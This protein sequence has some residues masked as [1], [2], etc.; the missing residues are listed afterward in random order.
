MPFDITYFL[1]VG[2]TERKKSMKKRIFTLLMVLVMSVLMGVAASAVDS[3]KLEIA[4]VGSGV[5]LTALEEGET[6]D[7]YL[8]VSPMKKVGTSNNYIYRVPEDSATAAN[9]ASAKL[10]EM[11]Y[12]LTWDKASLEVSA[13]AVKA[14]NAEESAGNGYYFAHFVKIGITTKQDPSI[15]GVGSGANNTGTLTLDYSTTKANGFGMYNATT[16]PSVGAVAKITFRVVSGAEGGTNLPITLKNTYKYNGSGASITG[17]NI[18]VS[19]VAGCEHANKSALSPAELAAAGLTNVTA[20]CLVEGKTWYYCSDCEKNI[21]ITSNKLDHNY[22]TEKYLKEPTCFEGGQK[23]LYCD[24]EG[25]TEYDKTNVTNVG[26]YGHD[27]TAQNHAYLEPDCTTDGY[28]LYWCSRCNGVAP[29]SNGD[30]FVYVVFDSGVFKNPNGS[31]YT[32]IPNEVK[33]AATGHDW[34]WNRT[35]GNIAYYECSRECGVAEKQVDLAD[36]VRYVSDAGGGDGSSAQSTVR[37]HEAFDAFKDFPADVDCTIYLVGDVS[38]YHHQTSS[39]NS[40][41]KNFEEARHDATVTITTAPNTAKAELHFPFATASQYFLGGPTV[42]DNITVTSTAVGTTS[43]SSQSTTIYARGFDITFT[44]NFETYGKNGG[45]FDYSKLD[46]SLSLAV[47]T[48]IKVPDC[49]L[50]VCGGFTAGGGY[51][52]ADI[53][54]YKS[55]M[56]IYGG[57]FFVIAGGSRNSV[58]LEDTVVDIHVGGNAKVAQ[59]IPFNVPA[60]TNVDGSAV[61]IHYHGGFE[62]A[63]AYVAQ[64]AATGGDYTVN[65]LFHEGS[66]DIK[67]GDFMMG[68]GSHHKNVN[69]FYYTY[70][71]ETVKMAN[72]V[73][74]KVSKYTAQYMISYDYAPFA[75]WCVEWLGGHDF[76][77]GQCTFCKIEPCQTHN[78]VNKVISLPNCITDGVSY[79]YCTVCF[80]HIGEEIR[81]PLIPDAH[82]YG[83]DLSK[84]PIESVCEYCGDVRYTYS[85]ENTG[86]IYV[87]DNGYGDGGFTPDYPLNDYETA[88]KMAAAFNGDATIYVVDSISVYHNY[89]GTSANTVFI[90]PKHEN[91][92]TVKGYKNVGIFKFGADKGR[93]LYNLNGDTT[94]ENI[95]FSEGSANNTSNSFNYIIAAHNHLTIG[96][97][98]TTAFERNSD[99]AYHNG[100]I[101]VVGGCY[102]SNYTISDTNN[103]EGTDTHITLHSGNFYSVYGG[104]V[105]SDCA[106]VNGTINVEF[107][108]DI[109]ISDV[110]AA[111]SASRAAGDVIITVKDANVSTANTFSIVGLNANDNANT[112]ENELYRATVKNVTLK[113]YSGS[114]IAQSFQATQGTTALR[115]LGATS[116]ETPDNGFEITQHLEKLTIC[117][118]PSN[119]SAVTAVNSLKSSPMYVNGYTELMLE[120]MCEASLDGQHTPNGAAKEETDSTCSAQ[121]YAIYTC[122]ACGEDYTEAKNIVPHDYGQATLSSAANCVSPQIDKEI[123]DVCGFVNYVINAE[124]PATPDTHTFDEE[125]GICK[126][127]MLSKQDLCEHVWDGGVSITT[128]CGTGMEYTCTVCQKQRIEVTSTEHNYGK[129]TVTVTPTETEPGI[130]TRTCKSCGKVD[131][132]LLYADGG[133]VNA[134]AIAVDSTGNLADFDIVTS[135]LTKSEREVLNALLQDTAYGSEIKV[136]YKTNGDET[137]ITYSIPLPAEYADMENVKVVV[138]DDDGKL[139]NVEFTVE[140]G[141]IVFTF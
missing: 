76:V 115:P 82:K 43:S 48:T 1:Y 57:T 7:V 77:E 86:V 30:G 28:D 118:D 13:V 15:T 26:A 54:T 98:V 71:N 114:L 45:T 10:T 113:I 4:P 29:H 140:K 69:V 87:S 126:Y 105:Y 138:K 137:N 95:E 5:D 94:F 92:V 51:N 33:L 74:N 81:I 124:N 78:I 36:T 44:E 63:M 23:A 11:K 130:K 101:V 133:A 22:V 67:L 97:N 79:D 111:G 120:D 50:Y 88:F 66:G 55:T 38:L 131:T 56:N 134:D 122:A 27:F 40:A 61:N 85:G 18:T 14:T 119:A 84:S 24:T 65:H 135:K 60:N 47:P 141:Y 42:F 125:T 128:G 127:C 8:L 70:D 117:Y 37:L 34:V 31:P 83:W 62:A 75:K 116:V 6:F 19:V 110:F 9:N 2:Q 64:N 93:I 89:T 73:N 41:T 91:T 129:F 58:N 121:G 32:G 139:H 72:S 102:Y 104:S 53:G 106:L 96:E 12:T 112:P 109:V 100:R 99:G 136:S 3:P 20:T 16:A 80:E 103:C 25:C 49:K 52:G 21:E 68:N 17:D 132:A 90:E 59:L 107:F 35:E 123:C 39:V 108:G 46:G